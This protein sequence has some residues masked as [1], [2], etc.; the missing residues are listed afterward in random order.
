MRDMGRLLYESQPVFRAA[1]D[2]CAA[3]LDKELELPILTI[4]YP[5]DGRESG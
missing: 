1:L 2:R 5:E 4:L 3:I